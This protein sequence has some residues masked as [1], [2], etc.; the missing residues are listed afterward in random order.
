MGEKQYQIEKER[1][2]AFHIQSSKVL[3][4]KWREKGN[5]RQVAF[6]E[7]NLRDYEQEYEELCGHIFFPEKCVHCKKNEH[8]ERKNTKIVWDHF[9]KNL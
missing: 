8:V 7:G 3:I 2:T 9:L 1:E 5:K 6:W 4:K